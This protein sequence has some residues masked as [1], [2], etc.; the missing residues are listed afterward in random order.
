MFRSVAE[1]TVGGGSVPHGGTGTPVG[2][3]REFAWNIPRLCAS[4]EF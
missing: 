1:R 4:A 2:P 3:A